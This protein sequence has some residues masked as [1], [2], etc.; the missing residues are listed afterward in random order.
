MHDRVKKIPR[1]LGIVA[2]S[3][4]FAV[5]TATN[6]HAQSAEAEALFS[7][8]SK[9]MKEGKLDQACDALDASNRIEP[10]AGTLIRIG[11]CREKNHQLAS[12][13]SAYKDALN[14]VKDPR[15]K[16]VAAAKVAELEPKLS[17]LT[18]SVADDSRVEGLTIIRNGQPLDP[19]LW[20]RGV[21]VNGGEY[22][23]G[24]QAPGHEEW[25]TTVTVPV[26]S[27]KVSV[28]V[29]KFKEIAK[30]VAPAPAPTPIPTATPPTAPASDPHEAALPPS[31]WTG[32]RKI[33]IGLAGGSSAG[34]IAGI[35]FGTQA[36]GKHDDA[37][38]LCTSTQIDCADAAR[39]NELVKDGQNRALIANIAFGAAAAMAIGAGVL[40]FTGAPETQTRHV[41]VAPSLAPGEA[42]VVM[43]G[44]F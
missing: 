39:A 19:G 30:L 18:I 32:K 40:W 7:E 13:W 34:L 28:E 38:K 27:G 35:V 10:R 2:T 1:R 8:G 11:E 22:V 20:N 6:A 29:P 21:P 5:L 16:K 31:T 15:K 33:A 37:H 17:Y 23:I 14:R 24:G 43:F 12:A 26:E 41:A 42:G 4:L 25:K 3:G 36:K 44:R 9:L